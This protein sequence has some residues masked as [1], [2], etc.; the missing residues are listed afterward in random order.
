MVEGVG[1][2]AV[3]VRAFVNRGAEV[4]LAL[5]EFLNGAAAAV[6]LI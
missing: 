3:I 1:R 4:L 6:Y 5:W 2:A